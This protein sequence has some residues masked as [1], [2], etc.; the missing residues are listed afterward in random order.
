[1]KREENRLLQTL[2]NRFLFG[3][4]SGTGILPVRFCLGFQ[5]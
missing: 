3:N 2:A 5:K 1:M 4:F